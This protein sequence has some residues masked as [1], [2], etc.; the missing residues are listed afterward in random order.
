MAASK[1]DIDHILRIWKAQR[2]LDGIDP[3]DDSSFNSHDDL[4]KAV[5]AIPFGETEW[6]AFVVRYNGPVTPD[7]PQ[8]K[9]ESF[10]VYARNT[11]HVL[12][13]MAASS[14]FKGSWHTRPYRQWNEADTRMYSDL[15]SADWAWKQAVRLSTLR[16]R[17][18]VHHLIRMQ[19]R[20]TRLLMVQCLRRFV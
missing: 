19:L 13:N 6:S 1:G 3:N 20:K 4:F 5:D 14:D 11:L 9:R 17:M 10:V 16:A 15:L 7:A 18:H 8:W 12:E 2:I